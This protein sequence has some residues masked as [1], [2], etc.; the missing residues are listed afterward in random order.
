[1]ITYKVKRGDTLSAI[2]KKFKIPY[3]DVFRANPIIKDPNKIQEGWT[4]KIPTI[5]PEI[6]AIR[7]LEW[8]KIPEWEKIPKA[9]FP[10]F[11]KKEFKGRKPGFPTW[12]TIKSAAV[13]AL[14]GKA[15]AKEELGKQIKQVLPKVQETILKT[16]EKLKEFLIGTPEARKEAKEIA[17]AAMIVAPMLKIAKIPKVISEVP[18]AAGEAY[19]WLKGIPTAKGMKLIPEAAKIVKADLQKLKAWRNVLIAKENLPIVKSILGG[20]KGIGPIADAYYDASLAI[21]K[22]PPSVKL[23]LKEY[24]IKGGPFETID[25]FIKMI[26]K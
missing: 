2:G 24:F 21:V 23:A 3:M 1:M 22:Y 12:E 18:L 5:L 7:E 13:Y 20:A 26:P 6:K 19:Q 11:L 9:E 4:L 15:G 8:K 14:K 16:P 25:W 10:S 17:E